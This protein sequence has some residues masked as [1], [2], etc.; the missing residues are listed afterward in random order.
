MSTFDFTAHDEAGNEYRLSV[1]LTEV[2][3][4]TRG[5][6]LARGVGTQAIT[7]EDGKSVNRISKGRYQ[8]VKTGLELTSDNPGAP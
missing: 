1:H 7:T 2:D 4:R 3:L 6:P 5:N 8:V